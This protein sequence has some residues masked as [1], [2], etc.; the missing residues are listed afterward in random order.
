MNPVTH[1]ALQ[2]RAIHL[3]PAPPWWPPAPGWWALAD[4]LLV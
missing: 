2:L 1:P 3:P 4:S